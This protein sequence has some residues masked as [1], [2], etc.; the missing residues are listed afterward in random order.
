[1]RLTF[2]L[3]TFFFCNLGLIAQTTP[4]EGIQNTL[5]R[6]N[7]M[8]EAVRN[9]FASTQNPGGITVHQAPE[10]PMLS[11]RFKAE[12]AGKSDLKGYR[13]QVFVGD[14]AKASEIKARVNELYPDMPAEINYL[15][16]NFRV[17]V[18]NFR[19]NLDA[20]RFLR[21]IKAD[22]NGAYIVPDEIGLPGLN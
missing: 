3:L 2:C 6:A 5:P 21:Q 4:S 10:I 19:T 18:G 16:P 15:A 12:H 14:R 7:F 1:M 9:N 11:S 22:F 20:D 8:D 13:V 17:R